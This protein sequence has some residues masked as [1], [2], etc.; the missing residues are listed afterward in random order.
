MSYPSG[1]KRVLQRDLR[2]ALIE[3]SLVLLDENGIE[4]LTL[5]RAAAR[6]GVSHAAP[7][8]HF[9]GLPGLLEAVA[10]RGFGLFL[11]HL[12]A[13]DPG[14]DTPP[15]QRMAQ[16][17]MGYLEF[18]DRH[19]ALF[20]L[21]FTKIEHATPQLREAAMRCYEV[22]RHNS[23]PF[24]NG[25]DP[26]AMETAIWALTHGYAALGM[27]RPRP[28]APAQAPDYETLLRLLVRPSQGNGD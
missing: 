2:E 12:Q 6:V 15:F 28:R 9:D 27:T 20:R 1:N 26:V 7:A 25:C 13:A 8:H 17:N 5:R 10:E 14:P 21:M 22:L 3:A 11:A 18:A 4:G 23:A 16:T 19:P 24:C